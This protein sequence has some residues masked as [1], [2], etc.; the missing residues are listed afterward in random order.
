MAVTKISTR[1][2]RITASQLQVAAQEP[3]TFTRKYITADLT[4]TPRFAL[5]LENVTTLPGVFG[6]T[7]GQVNKRVITFLQ[8]DIEQYLT[9][10]GETLPQTRAMFYVPAGI[11]G[12]AEDEIVVTDDTLAGS[13]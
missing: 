8:A 9:A 5:I 4:K 1:Q 13:L 11:R 10:S 7:F 12:N 3:G 6:S 2:W